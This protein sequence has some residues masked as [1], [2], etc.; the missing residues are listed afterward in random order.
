MVKHL[1]RTTAF[2]FC[3]SACSTAEKPVTTHILSSPAN[4]EH[5]E[6]ISS[7]GTIDYYPDKTNPSEIVLKGTQEGRLI[8]IKCLSAN[9]QNAQ[10]K[11]QGSGMMPDG[12]YMTANTDDANLVMV[13]DS[14]GDKTL[15]YLATNDHSHAVKYVPTIT[16]A[17]AWEHKGDTARTIGKVALY[18]LL[19]GIVV[20]A[21]VAGGYA[22]AR[23]NEQANTVTTTCTNYG[24]TTTCTSR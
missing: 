20:T 23:E 4:P 3:L 11:I 19:I 8:D 21:A 9:C 17:N 12:D 15:G 14:S 5:D 6:V 2:L 22:A 7:Q 18:T 13:Q 1:A 24:F 10:F 16:D